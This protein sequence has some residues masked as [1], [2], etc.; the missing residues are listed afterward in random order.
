[1]NIT[2]MSYRGILY[3]GFMACP[4]SIP[5]AWNLTAAVPQALDELLAEAGLEPA[6]YRSDEADAAVRASGVEVPT[7]DG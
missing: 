1:V 2:I 4:E 5:R 6:V 3:W 7:R